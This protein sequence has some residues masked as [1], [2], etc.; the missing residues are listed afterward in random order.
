MTK[1]K[2]LDTA[3]VFRTYFPRYNFMN[4]ILCFTQKRLIFYFVEY[5]PYK[6][7]YP[8]EY[9]NKIVKKEEE[10]KNYDGDIND[11]IKNRENSFDIPYEDITKIWFFSYYRIF[12][13]LNKNH[14]NRRVTIAYIINNQTLVKNLFKKYCTSVFSKKKK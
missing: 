1:E 4:F 12:L 11:L 8:S 3:P 10:L 13:K 14:K 2:I 9:E 7:G 5:F 6:F